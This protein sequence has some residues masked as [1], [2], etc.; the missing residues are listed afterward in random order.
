[1]LQP[2]PYGEK[3]LNMYDR[4][5]PY[6]NTLT[7]PFADFQGASAVTNPITMDECSDDL[8]IQ[9]IGVNFSNRLVDFKVQ[10]NLQYVW[11]QQDN[12]CPISVIAGFATQVMPI[13][14]L[15][16]EYFIQANN[17]LT[18]QFRNAPTG[19]E[20]SN[21]SLVCRGLRLKDRIK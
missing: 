9:E 1:M 14:P 6:F 19:M 3:I 15:P 18:W 10:D 2:T 7:I 16:I 20:T 11:T 13:L 21:R 12:F 5:L 17:Q 4:A 8:L